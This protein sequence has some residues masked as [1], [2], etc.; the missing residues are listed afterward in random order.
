[1]VDVLT[2]YF[3]LGQSDQ[4]YLKSCNR[5]GQALLLVG[6]PYNQSY[7]IFMKL[8][9][10]EEQIIL[11]KKQDA[12]SNSY[13]FIL[14]TLEKFAEEQGVVFADWITGDTSILRSTRTAIFQQRT[15]GNGKSYAYI[16]NDLIKA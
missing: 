8:S 11:G 10:L 1:M 4:Q 14:P 16:K 7:H 2:D 3:K 15:I 9:P 5:Q 6:P 13:S 12:G